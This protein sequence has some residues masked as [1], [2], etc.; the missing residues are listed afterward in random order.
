MERYTEPLDAYA[1]MLGYAGAQPQ[2][3]EAWKNLMVN[4]THDS[5]HGSSM[6]EVHVE[7][8]ARFAAVRQIA[9]GLTHDTLKH[10][11]R[12]MNPWWQGKGNGILTFSPANPGAPQICQVWLPVGDDQVQVLD[13]D[14]N[15][16]PTQVLPRE[17]IPLNGIGKP[18]HSYWPNLKF[19]HVLFLAAAEA[20]QI[21]S[22]ACVTGSA[23]GSADY[24]DIDAS[25]H[26]LENEH[27]RV[28]IRGGLV[29]I[30]DRHTGA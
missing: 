3:D 12:H 20:N 17:E 23:A 5:I 6:D 15:A 30:L 21:N 10:I 25:A 13:K 22:Y 28:E 4:S 26:H 8:E 1:S 7:M 2:L 14:G 27:L 19:R 11:G 29:N 24:A 9:A 18:R 16:L